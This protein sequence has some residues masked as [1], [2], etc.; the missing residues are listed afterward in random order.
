MKKRD[1]TAERLKNTQSARTPAEGTIPY[2][3]EKNKAKAALMMPFKYGK[4]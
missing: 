4:A 2:Y 1:T 3:S